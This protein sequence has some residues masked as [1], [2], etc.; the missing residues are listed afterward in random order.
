VFNNRSKMVGQDR[1]LK[2][3][4][5]P[6]PQAKTGRRTPRI[7]YL[8]E[9]GGFFNINWNGNAAKTANESREMVH[10]S[11][12]KM[13]RVV[14]NDVS[15][16]TDHLFEYA[17]QREIT[18]LPDLAGVPTAPHK[19]LIPHLAVKNAQGKTYR[20]EWEAKLTAIV[21]SLRP[22]WF[23]LVRTSRR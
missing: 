21:S 7:A 22:E 14:V 18:I 10:A 19:H 3:P 8:Q 5:D 9:R 17:A 15:T 1:L 23:I 4:P 13:F 11:G 16:Q 2:T 20:E 6:T 12:S